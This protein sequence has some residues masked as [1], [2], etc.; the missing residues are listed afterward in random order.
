MRIKPDSLMLF[1]AGL[2]TRMGAL[3]TSRPKPLIEV[4]GKPLIDHAL[5]LADDAG[6]D[7]MVANIHYLP[8]QLAA[9]LAPRGVALSLEAHELLDTG[10]GLKQALPLLGGD[11]AFTLNSDAVWTGP[12]P[13][14]ELAAL[15]QPDRMD[16]LL[17]LVPHA[18]A[19]AHQGPGDF[20]LG[21]DGALQRGDGFVYTGAQI[22]KTGP[23]AGMPGAVFSLNPVW[24]RIGAD[25]RLY[26]A[27]HHGGWC[28][29]GHPGGI[30]AAEQM[31]AGQDD[32]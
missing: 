32:V 24:D 29:V 1:A 28:D 19:F 31:L 21:K 9:H 27:V 2:G 4:A 3:C 7:T 8:E 20:R 11:A 25:G 17:L 15:W 18:Q 10:G 16:A 12:N 30:V 5:D 22:I 23:V 26:G 6:I 14:K 13:L